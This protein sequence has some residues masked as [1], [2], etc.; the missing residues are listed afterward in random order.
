MTPPT[1]DRPDTPPPWQA[2]PWQV[3]L[4]VGL[5]LVEAGILLG[6]TFWWVGVAVVVGTSTPGTAVFLVLFAGAVSVALVAAA[7][8][9]RR[10]SRRARAPLVTWQLLQALVAVTLLQAVDP[11]TA[12][13][14]GVGLA[15]VLAG[16]VLATVLSPAATRTVLR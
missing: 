6:V 15:V 2:L 1:A 11:P 7:R 5:V 4:G 8:A 10:G 13:L 14:W 9:L 12:L 3:R 16:G